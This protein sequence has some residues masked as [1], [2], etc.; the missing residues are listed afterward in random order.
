MQNHRE[1]V[2]RA[3]RCRCP[4][5]VP[6]LFVMGCLNLLVTMAHAQF[7]LGTGRVV[8]VTPLDGGCISQELP[9]SGT[10]NW[11][12][13]QVFRYRVRLENVTECSGDTIHVHLFN[14]FRSEDD[15]DDC[16]HPQCLEATRVGDGA[17]EFTV[18]F[19]APPRQGKRYFIRYCTSADCSAGGLLA[20]RSDGG[21]A[22]SELRLSRFSQDCVWLAEN[23]CEEPPVRCRDLDLGCFRSNDEVPDCSAL[24]AL[25][26][27]TDCPAGFVLLRCENGTIEPDPNREPCGYRRQNTYII[28]DLCTFQ[29]WEL[30]CWVFWQVDTEPPVVN[31]VPDKYDLGCNPAELP[32]CNDLIRRFGIEAK[33]N[34][35]HAGYPQLFCEAGEVQRD[36][37]KYRQVF[38]FWA[39]DKCGN[40]SDDYHLEVNWQIDR[41]PPV[42][43]NVPDK[44]DLGCNPAELPTCNDLIRRFGIEAKDNCPHAGYPQLFCEAGEVQRDGCKYR[45]VFTFWAVDK[46]GNRSDDY[47]LE[48]N[49]QIDREPPVV[50]NVPDKYDLGCNPAELPTCNDLIRRFGIE[51]KDNCPHAGYPQLFCEAGEVQRDGCKYRQVFTFWAVDKC[52][53]RSDDYH[54]E[55]N[56]QID[57]EPPVVNNVPDKY[58]LGCNPAELPTCNDLIRRFGIEAKD[59]CPHA[60]Y[61]QLFCEAGEVQR[62]GCKYRQVFTFWAVDKCGNRSD[63]YHL[64]VNWQID[65]EPPVVNN[66]PDKY[67]LGCNPAEL[68]TC[69]DLIRRFGI[70]AKDNCPH[71]GYPQLFCEAGE[72]QRDGCKYRQVFTFWAVDKCGNRSDDYH[73]EVNWQIDREPPVVNNVPD[74]YDLGCNPAELPTCNDLIRRFGIE[75]KD[76]CP[77][78][79]YPQ[80]FC[81]AGEV[82]R[83][84]CKY[85]QVFTFWAVDKCGNR[86]DDYHLEVNWQIDR[87]PPVVNNV[88]DKYDLGCNP[89]ELPTCNDLIRRFGIE[90]KDNC[91]HA[92]YPQLFCEAGEVQR[93]GCKY[94]QVF[95]FWA[96]DKCGNR[97]DDYHLE[98]NW[99]ID[100]EP[101]VVNNV[102]DKYDLGCNPAELPTCNDLIRRF[103]IEAKDNC[104]HAGYPILNCE[105]GPIEPVGDCKYRQVFTFWAEDKCG[106]RSDDYH[107]E[108]NWQVDTEPPVVNNVPETDKLPC[109]TRPTC[110][111]LIARHNIH[112]KDN[113]THEPPTLRCEPGEVV[114]LGNCRFRQTFTFWAVDKCGNRSPD[115]Q[116]VVFWKE[117]TEP[118]VLH[119]VPEDRDLGCNPTHIPDCDEIRSG[120][121][122]TDNCDPDVPVTCTYRDI[123]I[124]CLHIRSFILAAADECGNVTTRKVVVS[125]TE[126][127][128]PPIVRCPDNIT[129][130]AQF[131]DC[132]VPVTWRAKAEDDCDP[133]PSVAC[134]PPSGSF[135]G[136]GTTTVT[137]TATDRCGNSASCQFTVTVLGYICGYKFR[138]DNGNGVWEPHLGRAT[139]GRLDNRAAGPARECAP[140]HH[141]GTRR[142]V[143]LPGADLAWYLCGV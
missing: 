92:G 72:V 53:N 20:R 105:A 39:V 125:W 44:Y 80:L 82:Q 129:V 1:G 29:V 51:A 35:P 99:Q 135:F 91:P 23:K 33:D 71:A 103:G 73:L 139:T 96:V 124:G 17:Y 7:T 40:R 2:V 127:T 61:P 76:N 12:I 115:Y 90:A 98:V 19:P 3:C 131:P 117:D 22:P 77:H 38:T 14:P 119:N 31:N 78:A 122:A 63:D 42:V 97:S 66:V 123:V 120:V 118:P 68:P 21:N 5:W 54:L 70:E 143:L 111:L 133:R 75:A 88:P 110:D 34:C 25:N 132:L 13:E 10:E 67:D 43:N 56:W 58:D 93:D 126:D 65:R 32:T 136:L 9:P 26:I 11:N 138:D 107:L 142:Q 102:P 46:C 130:Q 86:S 89:A 87:E 50:N 48:V 100:R 101:P 116:L 137:C 140:N 64:E 84:G 55:V 30:Q 114:D 108:V 15:P 47:H 79:G 81:E 49:W 16:Y 83:D 134:N 104:P 109:N 141:D 28:K 69:N 128:T 41:E 57:R 4:S 113:C 18:R 37:C 121:Y 74:K 59:N 45:Q 62:D 6:L 85:R 8:S 24:A 60:G 94:R 112:A 95:T 27:E 52:G 36:G 106:N